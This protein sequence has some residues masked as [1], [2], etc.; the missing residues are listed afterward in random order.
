[1]HPTNEECLFSSAH[2]SAVI[3]IDHILSHSQQICEDLCYSSNHSK[4]KKSITKYEQFNS[5]M[6]KWSQEIIQSKE[7]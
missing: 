3:K 1:M 7:I 5:K 6:G 2:S 4:S